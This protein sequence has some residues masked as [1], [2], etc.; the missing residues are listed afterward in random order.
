MLCFPDIE[1]PGLSPPCLFCLV[2]RSVSIWVQ[3]QAVA[4]VGVEIHVTAGSNL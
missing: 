1:S 4:L 2:A 3:V